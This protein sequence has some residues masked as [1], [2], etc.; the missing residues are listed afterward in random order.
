M[1]AILRPQILETGD[2][3]KYCTVQMNL[4][5]NA[6]RQY[7]YTGRRYMPGT[8]K[9]RNNIGTCRNGSPGY[10]RR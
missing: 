5:R 1:P 4:A 9:R 8:A 2:D 7:A 3:Q 6:D 10:L